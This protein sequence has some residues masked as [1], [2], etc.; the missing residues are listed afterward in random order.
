MEVETSQQEENEAE[1]KLS[2][3]RK[4]ILTLE[5]DRE[6]NQLN[7]GMLK[8]YEDLK[9]ELNLLNEKLRSIRSKD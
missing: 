3:V 4:R 7:S 8:Q 1:E 6:N 9:K 2:Q 5:W